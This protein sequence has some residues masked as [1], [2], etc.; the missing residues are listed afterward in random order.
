MKE[1][2]DLPHVATGNVKRIHEFFEKLAYCVQSL[3]TLKQLNAVN[4]TVSMTLEKLPAIRRD[5]VRNDSEWESW[6]FI[7][8]TEALRLWTRRNQVEEA[9]LEDQSKKRDQQGRGYYHY[10]TQRRDQQ[11]EY[12]RQPVRSRA[13][14]YCNKIEH[15]SSDCSLVETTTERKKILA[16]KKMCFNCTGPA[17][18]ASECSSTATCRNCN[19]RHHTSI[20]EETEQ[21]KKERW[22]QTYKKTK[23]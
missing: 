22:Q 20:C 21:P 12:R 18:R 8:F 11:K 2:L 6:D 10:Q 7:Q 23:K 5:L 3:E 19:K 14:V 17:H 13:C 15:R 16:T 4:C 9:K 1:I